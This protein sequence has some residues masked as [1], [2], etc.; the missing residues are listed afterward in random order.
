VAMPSIPACWSL[1]G[2]DSGY[3]FR[4]KEDVGKGQDQRKMLTEIILHDFREATHFL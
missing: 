3:A 1:Q 2:E 4:Q